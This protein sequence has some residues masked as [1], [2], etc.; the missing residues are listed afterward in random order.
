MAPAQDLF[1]ERFGGGAVAFAEEAEVHRV[2]VCG[3]EHP[4]E[5][6]AT[7]SAGGG[8][9][10]GGW[11]C[12]AADHGGDAAC[13]GVVDLL[14][15]D[16]MDMGVDSASCDD[17]ALGRDYFRGCANGHRMRF[18][19]DRIGITGTEAALDTGVSGVADADDAAVFDAD[20]GFDDAE[21]GVD[22]SERW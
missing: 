16:E 11:A 4:E 6:P 8:V 13:E 3:F 7:R 14:R 18:S 12:A 9:G 22:E 15:A 10:S 5:V 20:V 2:G 17:A 21:N 1:A 19:G